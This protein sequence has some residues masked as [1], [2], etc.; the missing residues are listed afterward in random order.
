MIET[1]KEEEGGS[2]LLAWSVGDLSYSAKVR[3]AL[4]CAC[5][6]KQL[7]FLGA[8]SLPEQITA[9]VLLQILYLK[10]PFLE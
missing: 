3:K 8:V 9:N 6:W 1:H 5:F 7:N 2:C 4:L 10:R